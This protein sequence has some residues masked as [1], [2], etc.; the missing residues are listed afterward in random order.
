MTAAGADWPVLLV[1]MPFMDIDTPSIQ[2]GLL[3]SIVRSHGYP[4]RTVHANLGLAAR[5]G[6]RTYRALAQHRGSMVGEWLFSVAA[7]GADAPDPDGRLLDDCADDLAYLGDARNELR[8]IRDEVVPAFLDELVETLPWHNVRVAGFTCTFQQNAASIALARR[9]KERHPRVVT[10]FG[11]AG[12]DGE[13]GLEL[14]RRTASMD[15][16]VVGEGDVALPRL[17]D[18]LRE[19]RDPTLVPGVAGRD[20]CTPP[21]EPLR[22][23]DELPV[24]DYT[25]YF[26]KV[27]NLDV[28]I[29]FESARGCWWGEKHHC[30]F[31]GLNGTAM[32]FRAKSAGRVLAELTELSRRHHRFQ[33]DAVDN[34]LDPRLIRDL[35]PRLAEHNLDLFYEVKANLTRDQIRR[36]AQ[37]GVR[38]LQPGLESLSSHVLGLMRKGVRAAQ[39][40]N[41]LRWARYYGIRIDWN[42]LWGL[43][44]EE[45]GDYKTQA[46]L[47]P[48]LAHLQPPSSAGRIWMERFSPIFNDDFPVR[49]RQPERS[50]RYVYPAA[51]DL[52]RVAYFFDY[53]LEG[54]LP[55]DTYDELRAAVGEWRRA[56]SAD[57]PTLTYRSAPGLLQIYDGRRP[58]HEG[59]YTFEGPLADI[60][61]ACSDRPTTAKAV[62]GGRLPL[63]TVRAALDGFAERGLMFLDGELALSLALPSVPGR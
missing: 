62:L 3:S 8:R 61:L 7:F 18:A 23:L 22:D 39:N 16:I 31:C 30:V 26:D 32:G 40:V 2:L 5:I 51:V 46:Q 10:V 33:F 17:L 56:W 27:G 9:V 1:S 38:R 48:H 11:G 50:Y 59:T 15:L 29:P 42:V 44:G 54:A 6:D 53:E 36:L 49:R 41:V 55:D 4:V 37:A 35:L 52:D 21:G 25:E 63:E 24:P 14:Q 34:I 47:V 13:M 43:P 19:G 20:G 58:G 57:D 45:A 28:R 60:Y 12:V